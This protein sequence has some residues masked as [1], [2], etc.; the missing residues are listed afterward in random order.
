[1]RVTLRRLLP[2]SLTLSH[3][4]S[5]TLSFPRNCTDSHFPSS[6]S[7]LCLHSP[8]LPDSAAISHCRCTS[9]RTSPLHL[10]P[11]SLLVL[12]SVVGGD[13]KSAVARH[14]IAP[15]QRESERR[16]TRGQGESDDGSGK[17]FPCV[18]ACV[19]VRVSFLRAIDFHVPQPLSL[20]MSL[21]LF[22]RVSD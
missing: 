8:L 14:R 11:R 17:S 1:M 16:E 18:S 22:S 5:P 7:L 13:I 4:L 10:R 19:C 6:R 2:F 20:S 15:G 12:F 9:S 21:P 3:K